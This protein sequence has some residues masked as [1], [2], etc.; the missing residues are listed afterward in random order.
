M[1]TTYGNNR[2]SKIRV[3]SGAQLKYIAFLSM[4][5]DH[6]NKAL[7]YPL[8]TENG[9]L[10]YVS[11]V[12]DILGRVAFPIFMFFLVEGFFKTGNRF[13]YLLNLII[14]GII[15]EI[16]FDLFQSAVFFQPNSNNV[17]FT[18]A[19]A[20]VMIW[21]IDELKV[22]KSYIIPPVLWFPVSIIIV[23]TVCLLSMIW[24]LDYEYHG[25]LIAYFFYIFRNNPILSIIGGYL[26]IFKTPWALLGFG[27]T[28][29]Y[30]GK[31]G[32]QNKI[33]NYLFYPVHLLILGLLRL[34]F[35]IGI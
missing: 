1:S 4:L 2:F 26:S 27:L 29:T 20:L 9:F 16:P 10:R 11:D 7:M 28:L 3:F 18:L 21:V 30:N 33:L 19:L 25:I 15:S 6:V 31:R 24:G 32:K 17:M 14:F 22:P 12:F 5:I 13:K 35:K 34:C 8:L 23:I